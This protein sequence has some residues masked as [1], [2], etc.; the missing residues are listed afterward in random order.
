M[1]CNIPSVNGNHIMEDDVKNSN[2]NRR[3]DDRV[4]APESLYV[5]I[6]TEP[7]TMGQVVEISSTGMAFTLV[8]LDAVSNRLAR[9]AVLHLDLFAGGKGFFLRDVEC[10]LVSNIEKVPSPSPSPSS[11]S[12]KRVG[13]QFEGLSVPQQVQINRLVRRRHLTSC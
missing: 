6:D 13:V 2:S 9:Q 8:D 3:R 7:Q 10:R 11:L 4:P 5:I 12:I 1:Q